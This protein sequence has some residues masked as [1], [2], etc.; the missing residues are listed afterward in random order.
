MVERQSYHL[1]NGLKVG[2]GGKEKKRELSV[3]VGDLNFK[4][5]QVAGLER[6]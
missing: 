6:A 2:D 1:E 3:D 5:V 4:T